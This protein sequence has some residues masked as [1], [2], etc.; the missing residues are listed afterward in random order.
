MEKPYSHACIRCG[1]T[2]T[3]VA[4]RHWQTLSKRI[5]CTFCKG[6]PDESLPNLVNQSIYQ[7]KCKRCG[8]FS[9]YCS[10]LG[11]LTATRKQ[12]SDCVHCHGIPDATLH[13]FVSRRVYARICPKCQSVVEHSTKPVLRAAV[14][15]NQQCHSCAAKETSILTRANL[16]A[17]W[18]PIIGY[19][20]Y[21][22]DTLDMVRRHW[23]GLNENEQQIILNKTS[24][25]RYYYWGH[26]KRKN[27]TTGHRKCR[28]IMAEK[29][30]GDN[31]WVRRPEVYIKILKSC[32][33]YKG[34]GH[35][36][37][38]KRKT[39]TTIQPVI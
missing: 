6:V 19:E 7:L 5:D 1:K 35:W 2:K 24:L 33:K 27:R 31:H 21:T 14:R 34:D 17:Q 36:F 25:Q 29:Y 15:T 18:T 30:S 3:Y 16:R 22:Y 13:L 32:E 28:E 38:N 4:K 8:T 9:E 23:E 12:S 39:L 20:N 10:K 11:L 37:R 26:L